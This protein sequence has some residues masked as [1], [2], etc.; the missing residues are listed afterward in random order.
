MQL[1]FFFLPFLFLCKCFTRHD[2]ENIVLSLGSASADYQNPIQ[3]GSRNSPAG[4][5][6]TP[7]VMEAEL[8]FSGLTV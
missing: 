1:F 2:S 6:G 7:L 3:Q 8:L 4:W 5:R